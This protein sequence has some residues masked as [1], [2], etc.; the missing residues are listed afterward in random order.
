MHFGEIAGRTQ[1]NFFISRLSN[2]VA[3]NEGLIATFSQGRKG[4]SKKKQKGRGGK[5]K[6]KLCL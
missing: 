3:F 2:D 1:L 4:E 6:R 5:K